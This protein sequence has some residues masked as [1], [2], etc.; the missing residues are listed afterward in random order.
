MRHHRLASSIF[1]TLALGACSKSENSTEL[2]VTVWS[3]LA[4][5]AEMDA[6]RI[7]V[8]GMAEN[9]DRL[10][11]LAAD[12]RSGTYQIPVQLVLTPAASGDLAIR[13]IATGSHQGIDIVAQEAVLSFVP[14]PAR[15]LVLNLAQSCANV[16]CAA[17]PGY[18]CENGACARP[19]V[20]D[21]TTLPTY[22]PGQA[23]PSPDAGV[24][25]QQ[26]DAASGT[27]GSVTGSGGVAGTGG[28]TGIINLDAASGAG[29]SVKGGGGSGGAPKYDAP[30][31]TGGNGGSN[32]TV[33]V[34]T[35]LLNFGTVEIGTVS[36]TKT[37]AVTVTVAPVSIIATVI[38][39]GFAI[40]ANTCASMQ[41]LGTCIIGVVFAPTRQGVA[42]GELAVG[43]AKVALSGNGTAPGVFTVVPDTIPLGT[44]IVGTSAP[45]VVTI[46]PIGILDSVMCLQSGTDLTL[47]TTTC[48]LTGPVAAQC[49]YTYTFKA[50]TVGDKVD[51]I[52]CSGGGKTAQTT[53]TAKVVATP[54]PPRIVPSTQDFTARVG[55]SV[56]ATFSLTNYGGSPTGI[57]TAAVTGAGF[58]ITANECP[59]QLASLA[60]CKIQVTFAPATA[61]VVTGALTVTDATPGS[62]PGVAALTGTGITGPTGVITPAVKDFG[63]VGV[64]QSATTAFTITNGGSA[65]SDIIALATTEPQFTIVNDLCGGH[66]LASRTTCTF[67]VT[68]A[69][70]SAGLKQAIVNV[71]QTSDGAVLASASLTGSG[72]AEG[73]IHL[74]ISPPTI[75][76]GTTYV[77]GPVGPAVFTVKN[78]SISSVGGAAQ[79]KIASNTCAAALA[80]LATCQVGVTFDPT[81]VGSASAVIVVTDGIAST[82]PPA[83]PSVTAPGTVSGIAIPSISGLSAAPTWQEF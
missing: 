58:S 57:L 54:E 71:T 60:T 75:D 15:E 48:P 43:S 73:H 67:G 42:T 66:P 33:V 47:A 31:G 25:S 26:S 62:V 17:Y 29:G 18:T 63:T 65:A 81:L 50:T 10:F 74:T 53:V 46:I 77:G 11:P 12:K 61:G 22:V 55:L 7:Q 41:P 30:S 32:G 64:G 68:F 13:V 4:V 1:L 34:D 6:L 39:D 20:V 79:F 37:I 69:P 40:S 78:D 52:V 24:V 3:D 56:A 5:P 21:P 80:P 59:A 35:A 16:S 83:T 23:S 2:V 38:G 70:A 28:S 51:V 76:F 72:L 27:G 36:P 19:V 14:D 45:A 44:M 82:S 9:V 49:T 8:T